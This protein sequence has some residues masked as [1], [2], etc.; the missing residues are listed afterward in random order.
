MYSSC[1]EALQ[2]A[3]AQPGND[4][5]VCRL[6]SV[7]IAVMHGLSCHFETRSVH[8]DTEKVF[9]Q[10]IAAADRLCRLKDDF[11]RVKG[12][13]AMR[14]A[15]QHCPKKLFL[16]SLQDISMRANASARGSSNPTACAAAGCLLQMMLRLRTFMAA[17][18]VK[19]AAAQ[20]IAQTIA[21]AAH[22]MQGDP[23]ATHNGLLVAIA[24]LDCMPQAAKSSC[25]ALSTACHGIMQNQS[26][27][28]EDRLRAAHVLAAL[29]ASQNT[30][31]AHSQHLQGLL[32]TIHTTLS[33]VPSP[34]TDAG[35]AQAASDVLGTAVEGA[36]TQSRLLQPPRATSNHV[37]V[38]QRLEAIT[39]LLECLD[40]T[41]RRRT[42]MPVPLPMTGLVLLVSRLLA[43]RPSVVSQLSLQSPADRVQLHLIGGPLLNAGIELRH[44]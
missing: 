30:T 41:L 18:G 37:P 8:Q 40:A 3:P 35:A 42:E 34:A 23:M 27:A 14:L 36:W 9:R 39:L 28:L 38:L 2:L 6:H 21:S 1:L 22:L 24:V 4:D 19:S 16:A 20:C 26:L 10:C 32:H 7:L 15:I 12:L 29:P 31:D 17:Q 13:D 43:H 5:E 33:S 11:G 44:P 25:T